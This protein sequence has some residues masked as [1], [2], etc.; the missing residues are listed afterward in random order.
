MSSIYIVHAKHLHTTF[1]FVVAK[2]NRK[3]GYIFWN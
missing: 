3:Y 2:L 1:I